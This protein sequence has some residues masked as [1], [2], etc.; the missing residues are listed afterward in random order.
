MRSLFVKVFLWFWVA[1]TLSGA[2]L[3]LI[4][5]ATRPGQPA[6]HR[7]HGMEQL[8]VFYGETAAALLERGDRPAL[9]DYT[10]TLERT[11]GIRVV[12]LLRGRDAVL[13]REEPASARNLAER[14]RSSGTVEADLAGGIPVLAAPIQRPGGE[15]YLVVGL[16]P[17]PI[18]PGPPPPPPIPGVQTGLL[19]SLGRFA[20]GSSVPFL[21]TCVIGGLVCFGLAWH[22][23]A[24]IRLLRTATQRL[25]GGDLTA[26]VGTGPVRGRDEIAA[27][28][29]DFDLMAERIEGLMTGQ[30]RLLRDIS[31]ELRSPLARLTLALELARQ[32]SGVEATTALD[33]IDREA[34]RLNDLIGQLLTLTQLESGNA[35]SARGPV[36]L[37][38][39]VHAIAADANFEAETRDCSVRVVVEDDLTIAGSEE[40]LRRGIE[41]VVR[42]AVRYTAEHTQVDIAVCR[43]AGPTGDEALIRVRDR[44]PG[45]PET[46]LPQIFL[47]FYRVAEAR[48]RQTG[49]T[50]IGLA[51]S[52][53]A[54]RL[55]AGTVSAANA[56]GGGL[57]V[58]LTFLLPSPDV[59]SHEGRPHHSR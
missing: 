5:L 4:G 17:A 31:H 51:I 41:N 57:I 40:M 13:D 58:T 37:T 43:R 28:G 27:L 59:P 54:V 29:R 22:L 21:V 53:R 23:T 6:M 33:R 10:A 7:W 36:S 25:A 34:E 16:F 9:E 45:V 15:P 12:L 30:R 46:A 8:L 1:M 42:N 2:T 55:H 24:P 44:G 19:G 49:G 26:R 14:A 20:R 35:G 11:T 52:E 47:P 3:F 50:G 39:L 48:D 38:R 56:E 18:S 32:R